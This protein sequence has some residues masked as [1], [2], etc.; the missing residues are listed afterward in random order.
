LIRVWIETSSTILRSGLAALLESGAGL[1]PADSATDA[2]VILRETT[3]TH[4]PSSGTPVVVL[5]DAPPSP[6]LLRASVRA[7]LPRHAPPEQIVAA[8]HAAATG[9]IALPAESAAAMPASLSGVSNGTSEH[10]SQ[11]VLTPRELET[12]EMMSEG[13]SNKQIAY[14]LGISDH[15]AK[16]HVN[17]I[18]AKLEAGTRTEAVM[19][20]IRLGLVKL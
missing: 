6:T 4:S 7:V 11:E 18:F 19:R 12:L 14:R 3:L 15:T 1:E 9:L 8:L 20:G 13:L 16:F 2:D 17:S 10:A 5:T